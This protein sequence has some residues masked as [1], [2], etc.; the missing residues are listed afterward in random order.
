MP[1]TSKIPSVAKHEQ[2]HFERR[3][4]SIWPLCE[5]LKHFF[6]SW[7]DNCHHVIFIMWQHDM[8]ISV[9]QCVFASAHVDTLINLSVTQYTMNISIKISSLYILLHTHEDQSIKA[10]WWLFIDAIGIQSKSDKSDKITIDEKVQC[11]ALV[12][13][14]SL[15]PS[16][17][18]LSWCNYSVI[19]DTFFELERAHVSELQPLHSATQQI[20]HED[21]KL[22]QDWI[23]DNLSKPL[24]VSTAANKYNKPSNA[25]KRQD[26]DDVHY[27]LL[28]H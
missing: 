15:W 5:A 22:V 12:V 13:I 3:F 11:S 1:Y 20:I 26:S 27:W 25:F 7:G 17:W 4:S 21:V 28:C 16:L 18:F 10:R 14:L 2:W 23:S 8:N 6:S 19:I 9:P 24:E